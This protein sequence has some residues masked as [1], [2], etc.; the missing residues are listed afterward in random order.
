MPLNGA[1]C[2]HV[3]MEVYLRWWSSPRLLQGCNQGCLALATMDG[4]D[5]AAIM[6]WWEVWVASQRL[7]D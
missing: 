4:H 5:G 1:N 3:R 2:V 6:W 7:C